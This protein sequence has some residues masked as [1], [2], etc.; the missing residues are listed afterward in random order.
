MIV[1]DLPVCDI[2]QTS[3]AVYDAKTTQGPWAYM[4]EPCWNAY[5]VGRLGTGYGQKLVPHGETT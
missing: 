2:C 1:Q 5:G 4:C 3:T